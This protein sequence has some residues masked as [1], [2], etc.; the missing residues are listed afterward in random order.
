M[1]T[2]DGASSQRIPSLALSQDYNSQVL[3]ELTMPNVFQ[4]LSRLVSV[5]SY[6]SRHCHTRSM[7]EF[8][9][10]THAHT[11]G[12]PWDADGARRG[13]SA[14]IGLSLGSS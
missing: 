2:G 13:S 14:A 7:F 4:N 12:C 9:P 6:I 10:P 8:H 1:R 3:T 5:L 11:P